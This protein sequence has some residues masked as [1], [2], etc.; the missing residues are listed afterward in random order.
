[1]RAACRTFSHLSPSVH[2]VPLCLRERCFNAEDVLDVCG[3]MRV[4]DN[5][6]EVNNEINKP[7]ALTALPSFNYVNEHYT[8]TLPQGDDITDVLDADDNALDDSY[9]VMEVEDE[10]MPCFDSIHIILA[11]LSMISRCQL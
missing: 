8:Y 6:F 5:A 7:V 10:N 2:E 1:M 11:E 9:E 4:V 3:F